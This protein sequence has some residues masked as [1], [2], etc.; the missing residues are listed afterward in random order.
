M[1]EL[2]GAD[3]SYEP[4]FVSMVLSKSIIMVQFDTNIFEI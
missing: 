2:I 3:A 1:K 4:P